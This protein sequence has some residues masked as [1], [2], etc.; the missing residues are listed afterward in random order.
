VC[1]AQRENNIW[2]FGNK[3]GLD[4]NSGNPVNLTDG[5]IFT[6]EGCAA[7]SNISGQLLFYTDGRKV[8]NRNH[9]IMA[10]GSGL[11][12]HASSTQSAII[13]PKPNSNTIYYIFTTS[14][15]AD[16]NGICYSE[17]DITL[18]GG[19]GDV[20]ANKNIQLFAPTCEKICAVKNLTDGTYWVVTHGYEN[21]TFLAFKIDS[22]GVSTSPVISNV[23]TFVGSIN[24]LEDYNVQGYLK[25]SSSGSKLVCVNTYI[26][27]ELFDFDIQTGQ[28]NNP[29][30]VNRASQHRYCYGAEF[31]PSGNILYLSSS[32]SSS[33]EQ[34]IIYQYNLLSS[35][36]SASE[37]RIN[38]TNA[39]GVGALQLASN[40]K[41]YIAN[42]STTLGNRSLYVI[43][44]PD[45]LGVNCDFQSSNVP[46][47]GKCWVG[48]PQFIEYSTCK[49]RTIINDDIC[50]GGSTT[51]SLG[52]SENIT[53]AL[54]RFGDGNTSTNINGQNN[55]NAAGTYIVSGDFTTPTGNF[56]ISK[57]ITVPENPVANTPEDITLCGQTN[58]TYDL[59]ALSN[60]ILGNQSTNIYGISYFASMA[61]ATSHTNILS[62]IQTYVTPST[63]V[64][65]KV[66]RLSNFDCNGITSF[67]I[68]LS[69]Y[70]ISNPISEFKIC[71]DGLT[72]DGF[73]TFDL[74]SKTAEFLNGQSPNDFKVSYHWNLQ[75]AENNNNPIL[76]PIT[77]TTSPQTVYAR[78]A[79]LP[80]E[81]CY[82]TA[83]FSLVVQPSPEFDMKPIHVLCEGNGNYVE[84][85]VPDTFSNYY[86]STGSAASW[87]RIAI[88]GR[89]WV[90]VSQRVN[91]FRCSRT[92]E[93]QVVLANK[94]TIKKIELQDWTDNQN[95]I[96]IL[97]DSNSLG[98]YE[99][100]IDGINYQESN[101]FDGL[102]ANEYTVYVREKNG[103]GITTDEIFLLTYPKFFTP[104]DDGYNDEWSIRFSETEP[105][106][107]IKIFD[108]YGKLLSTL[109]S[110]NGK[111]EGKPLPSDDYWFVVTRENGKEY[112][113]HFTLKR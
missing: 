102:T 58:L 73:A 96:L 61:D 17:V 98:E 19:L 23:G 15:R 86:W 20:N 75:D 41:I 64:Y 101:L 103:C 82:K 39:R 80:A 53:T 72:N 40:C 45:I 76:A 14:E 37:T 52:G 70:P 25:F 26:N 95:S 11:R 62:P 54:W 83:S 105:N 74:N 18:N 13:V 87:T 91:R 89:F 33:I 10:N 111:F 16:S 38:A 113:G 84:V 59:S 29:I 42:S 34:N 30:I 48:L 3:A 8:W 79:T 55:Y 81:Q 65:A 36:I 60:T 100:S 109:L 67:K 9:Q 56:S 51:F 68:L 12:G 97:I 46:L 7:I 4:F 32:L 44:N 50:I 24:P 57:Q 90:K 85:S 66:Y 28:I 35:N 108:R 78:I 27:V 21:N 49:N 2:Y 43:N 93:F 88:P 69:D 92:K 47:S 22:A 5:Q 31:S 77:N 107:F 110:W 112:K 71:D 94:A 104:N 106:L 99:Y 6:I 63:V 1:H